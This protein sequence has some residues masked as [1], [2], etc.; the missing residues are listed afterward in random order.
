[1]SPAAATLCPPHCAHS[2]CPATGFDAPL[3]PTYSYRLP[4]QQSPQPQAPSLNTLAMLQSSGQS[5][6]NIAPRATPYAG[7]NAAN[8]KAS[9]EDSLAQLA[10]N[11]T[12]DKQPANLC[13]AAAY[14]PDATLRC[15]HA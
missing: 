3:M 13:V 2:L 9:L 14:S 11:L 8:N 6:P 7:I 4:Q 5:S 15:C 1:M 10:Q 12:I